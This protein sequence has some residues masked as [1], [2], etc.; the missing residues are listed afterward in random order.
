[1]SEPVIDKPEETGPSLLVEEVRTWNT[2]LIGAY[3]LW[4]FTLGYCQARPDGDAPVGLLHFIAGPILAS[5]RL[6]ETVSLRRNSLQSYTLGFEDKKQIDLLL[7][8]QER[9]R[10]RRPQTMAAIDAAICAGLLV[11]DVE[12]GKLYPREAPT[13][14]RGSN[15]RA[16]LKREGDKARVLGAWFAA[17]DLP[18]IAAYLKVVL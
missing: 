7:G 3:Q 4:Q 8:L 18:T 11:W 16:S 6:S 5:P 15:L 2:P 13:A 1:M 10:S 9:I 12:S 17:H 14:R